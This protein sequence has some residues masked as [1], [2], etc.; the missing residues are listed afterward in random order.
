MGQPEDVREQYERQ[1]K[2]LQDA[3]ARRCS[4]C[5]PEKDWRPCWARESLDGFAPAGTECGSDSCV[6]RAAVPLVRAAKADD[7]LPAED[8]CSEGDSGAA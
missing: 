2:D 7:L 8:V 3:S 4:S 5:A 6:D 1:L